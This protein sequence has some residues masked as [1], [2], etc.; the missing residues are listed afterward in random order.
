M[1]DL[2]VKLAAELRRGVLQ[3]AALAL[4][5]EA[6]YG[7]QL[8]KDLAGLGLETEEGTL[9]PILRRPEAQGLVERTWRTD[10]PRP[11]K[12][13]LLT[14][15]GRETLERLFTAW[16]GIRGALENLESRIQDHEA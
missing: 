2:E 5:R 1:K 8:L 6:T 13:Y 16:R 9:S 15:P 7:Y 14:D 11:R 3:I 4:M 10:G 12:Y